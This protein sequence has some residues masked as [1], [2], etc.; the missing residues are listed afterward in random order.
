M[1]LQKTLLILSASAMLGAAVIA[2]DV[3]L[4]QPFPA[5]PPGGPPPGPVGGPPPGMAGGPP[6]VS[7]AALLPG[8]RAVA[9]LVSLVLAVPVL[10]PLTFLALLA[11]RRSS[12]LLGR[13]R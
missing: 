12:R 1:K 9:L 4:A 3:A 8:P 11:R 6:P 13:S 10:G 2:P 7:P 5:P